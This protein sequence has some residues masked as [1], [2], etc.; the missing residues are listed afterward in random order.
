[1]LSFGSRDGSA[2]RPARQARARAGRCSPVVLMCC[3]CLIA[4][5]AAGATTKSFQYTGGQ[6]TFTVPVGVSVV[7]VVAIGGKG[8]DFPGSSTSEAGGDGARA[9]ADVAVT[10]GQ[11]LYV[12]VGGNGGAPS[13]CTGGAGGFN[14]GGNGGNDSACMGNGG[15]GG[16]GA[17][18]VRTLARAA[19]NSL[20]SRVV[21]AGGG[22]GASGSYAGGQA[23]QAG[24]GTH[25]AQP[26]GSG[27]GGAGG[28][29]P[30]SPGGSGTQGQ[31]GAGAAGT[32]CG[33]GGGGGGGWY[34]GGGGGSDPSSYPTCS[35]P[36]LVGSG[37]GGSSGFGSGAIRPSVSADATGIPSVTLT[38]TP[39]YPLTV[40]KAGTGAGAVTS[41]P[42]G[43]SC[44]K[45]CTHSFS[46]GSAVTLTAKP[47]S[48]SRFAGWSGACQGTRTCKVL[49]SRAE[50]VTASF[51]V[52][53]PPNTVIS[54][55]RIVTGQR[56]A[57]FDFRGSGGVGALRFQCKLDAGGWQTCTSPKVY[58][59]LSRGS[60]T[61]QVRAVDA[62]GQT[63]P[64]PDKHAFSI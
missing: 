22:A 9:V 25:P 47:A 59:K 36:D 37:A 56:K 52:V 6:Q 30:M 24:G 41:S 28:G 32:G 48:G 63:D 19:S 34:G 58:G 21:V 45:A 10:P 8:G 29:S 26:G 1:M 4:P 23:G 27:G 16:G 43:I 14:E 39:A 2:S 40:R 55:V 33:S 54:G 12:E 62:R 64:T 42:A 5:A 46:S 51:K 50:S 35:S 20:S 18:D 38:Y 7:H 44:G 61:F 49:M 53:P 3:V 13:I 60:H 57:T 17:S 11:V 31:G 15:A